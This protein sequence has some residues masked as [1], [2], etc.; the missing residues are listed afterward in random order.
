M[1]VVVDV[2]GSSQ[3]IE[4]S[5]LPAGVA[6]RLDA[7]GEWVFWAGNTAMHLFRAAFLEEVVSRSA[8]PFHCAVKKVSC[9][10]DSGKLFEPATENAVKFE[11][12]IF[13]VLPLAERHL[14]VETLRE[15][16]F[17]PLKNPSGDFGPEDVRRALARKFRGW[18]RAAGHNP[19]DSLTVEI[20][21]SLALEPDDLLKHPSLELNRATPLLLE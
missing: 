3:I 4:Y 16:E 21:A 8:L 1:G 5:D 6:G 7:R 14:V 2:D 12:F 13:D 9:L 10:D 18:L 17:C 19:P 11:K 15:E 20:S